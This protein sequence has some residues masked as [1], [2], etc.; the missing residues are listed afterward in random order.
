MRRKIINEH[1]VKLLLDDANDTIIADIIRAGTDDTFEAI[2]KLDLYTA[3]TLEEI[4][5]HIRQLNHEGSE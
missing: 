2:L 3:G 1:R 4:A 5:K